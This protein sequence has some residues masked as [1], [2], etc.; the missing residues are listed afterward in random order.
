MK[1]KRFREYDPFAWL[2]NKYWGQMFTP[3]AMAVIEKLVLSQLKGKARILDLCCGTG[4][5]SE[6]LSQRSY[7][8]TGIDG[9]GKMLV[10]ARE[11]APGVHFIEADAR[12]F[13]TETLFEATVCVFDSLNHVMSSKDLGSVF[14]SVYQA[15]K[16]KGIFLF[17]MNLE[18]EYTGHWSGIHGIV[19]DDHVCMINQ[20]YDSE[21]RIGLFDATLFRMEEGWQRVDFI[22]KQKWYPEEEIRSRLVKAGFRMIEAYGLS[23]EKGLIELTPDARRVFFRC[24]K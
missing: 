19:E 16:D 9:S 8:V 3:T 5:M 21:T 7:Q 6:I 1:E 4:Q 24:I 11:N 22:L 2:Y 10:Y 14:K 20:H 23:Q 15:L 12:S 18:P 17:D 13:T